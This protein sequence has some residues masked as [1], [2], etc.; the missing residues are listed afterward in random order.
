MLPYTVNNLIVKI[1]AR[2]ATE[3]EL[4]LHPKTEEIMEM[5]RQCSEIY[6]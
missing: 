6:N 5:Y 2:F 3:K 4:N 1:Y